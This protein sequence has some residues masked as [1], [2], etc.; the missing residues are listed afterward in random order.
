MHHSRDRGGWAAP[1]RRRERALHLSMLAGALLA[2]GSVLAACGSPAAPA[3][4]ASPASAAYPVTVTSCGVPVTYD[5]A[6]A[7]AVSNDINTTEDMLALGLE[8]HMAGTFGVTGDGPAGRPVPAPYLAGFRKVRDVS[9]DYFT[10]EEL[11]GLHPD[12]LFAG[13]NYGLQTGTSLTPAGLAPFGIKTLVLT[14]SCVHVQKGTTSVSIGDTYQDLRNLGAIFN[15]RKKAQQVI[16]SMQGQVAAAHAKVAGL[17]P[18]RVFDYDSGQ[19]APFTAPGLAMPTALIALGGG[20]NVFAGLKQSWTSVSWEQV[21]RADPQC[22][23][24]NDYGT[25]TAQQKEKFLETSKITRNLTAVKNHCFLTLSYDE[26]T[27][28]PRNA[29]AVV[30]IARWLHP[31]AFGLPA[32]GS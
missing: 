14:E 18:V 7:R 21:V 9:P 23:I 11:V 25:P 6:P 29:A 19:A 26:Q 31:A 2:A 30:A 20:T 8:S 27:P 13:W 16:S 10:R 1:R 12:F 4:S 28:G 32:G 3:T 15:V 5:R 22:I 24:I 17:K